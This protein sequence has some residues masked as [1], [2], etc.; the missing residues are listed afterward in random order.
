MGILPIE[1]VIKKRPDRV[2]VF[3]PKMDAPKLRNLGIPQKP[4]VFVEPRRDVFQ[5][6]EEIIARM[7]D[8]IDWAQKIKETNKEIFG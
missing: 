6:T 8:N 7:D 5:K 3:I 4:I 1:N 2:L